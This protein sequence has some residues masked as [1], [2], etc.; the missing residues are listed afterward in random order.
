[1]AVVSDIMLL[2]LVLR[3]A[4]TQA[5]TDTEAPDA[6]NSAGTAQAFGVDTTLVLGIHGAG[7]V[8][9]FSFSWIGGELA[10]FGFDED[11]RHPAVALQR[12]WRL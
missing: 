7:D 11:S 2:G 5:I 1:M 8:D 4:P 3:T 9:I 6:G 12:R 10:I